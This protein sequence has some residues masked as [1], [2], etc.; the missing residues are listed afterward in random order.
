MVLT[1]MLPSSSPG[2]PSARVSPTIALCCG[3]D[4]SRFS[5]YHTRKRE[6][7]KN[8]AITRALSAAS[9]K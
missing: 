8:D 6:R 9:E 1:Y 2:G 7:K 5:I 3:G 4:E